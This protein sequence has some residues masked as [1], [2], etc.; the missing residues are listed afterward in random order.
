M[1]QLLFDAEIYQRKIL[2]LHQF[3]YA[4]TTPDHTQKT[5]IR[6]FFLAAL[7]SLCFALFLFI[8]SDQHY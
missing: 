4:L 3:F 7:T 5:P 6:F 8:L 1:T 2:E